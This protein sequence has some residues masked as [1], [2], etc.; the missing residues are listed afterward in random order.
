MAYQMAATVVT[1]NDHWLQ[2]FSNAICRT[3]MQHR[4][5]HRGELDAACIQFD[6]GGKTIPPDLAA[7]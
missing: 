3:F 5:C 7:L 1:L 6:L 2:A 4:A